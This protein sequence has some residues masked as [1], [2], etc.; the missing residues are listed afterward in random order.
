MS[1]AAYGPEVPAYLRRSG[2]AALG[3]GAA[4]ALGASSVAGR[5]SAPSPMVITGSTSKPGGAS[6]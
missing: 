4:R 6:A 5:G 3:A 2:G 1:K